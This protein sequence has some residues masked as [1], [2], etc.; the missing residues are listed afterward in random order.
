MRNTYRR[1]ALPAANALVVPSGKLEAIAMKHWGQP[2]ERLK[3]IPNGIDTKRYAH[4]PVPGSIP[5]F[6]KQPGEVVIGSIAGLRPVKDLPMLVR[7]VAGMHTRARLVIV[8]EGPER[9]EIRRTAELMA[10]E[11]KLVMPGFLPD[12]HTYIGHFDI[13]ALSS[14]S[15]QAPVS[16]IE[17]MAAGLPVVAPWVG[18]I[19]NMVDPLNEPA[20]SP[21]RYEIGLRDRLELVAKDPDLRKRIGEANR[22]R[23]RALFEEKDM[24]AAYAALYSAAMGRPGILG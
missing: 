12:P 20:L 15:E 2:A 24:V 9:E 11:D 4:K 21:A 13:F 6:K 22:K 5:G 10:L 17:A 7:S 3:R 1:I 19:P 16:V 14:K 23:A 18:D 8:G